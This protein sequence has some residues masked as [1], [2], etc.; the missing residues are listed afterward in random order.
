MKSSIKPF[1]NANITAVH[2]VLLALA[3]LLGC[4]EEQNQTQDT[5]TGAENVLLDEEFCRQSPHECVLP[6]DFSNIDGGL[7][8][9][10]R[11][12]AEH[13]DEEICDGSTFTTCN[14]AKNAD[15]LAYVRLNKEYESPCGSDSKYGASTAKLDLDVLAVFGTQAIPHKREIYYP[16]ATAG[17]PM[18]NLRGHKWLVGI[19]IYNGDWFVV[20][21]IPAGDLNQEDH[22]FWDR[23]RESC[24]EVLIPSSPEQIQEDF[25][26]HL[27]NTTMHECGERMSDEQFAF[28][29]Q[30]D[31][32][33][34]NSEIITE[35]VD[36]PCSSADPPLCCID[37]A[38]ECE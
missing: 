27:Q 34:V 5:E 1:K 22:Y 14:L 4:N 12:T 36:D 16:T 3:L 20:S 10:L 11:G 13:G 6:N 9:F 18:I 33:C 26:Q 21:D 32:K 23:N 29:N 35:D 7:K 15:L 38:I 19:R 31:E 17:R 28:F 30:F 8:Y 37:D 24:T 25:V 2:V